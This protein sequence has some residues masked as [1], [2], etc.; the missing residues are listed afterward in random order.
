MLFEVGVAP[1]DEDA[2]EIDK[3]VLLLIASAPLLPSLVPGV[4]TL[5]FGPIIAS[6]AI[7]TFR[8]HCTT[9][10]PTRPATDLVQDGPFR[11]TRNPMY[12]ALGTCYAGLALMMDSTWSLLLLIPL[13]SVVNF[14]V[15]AR[16][17]HWI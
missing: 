15:T 8:R 12:L 9:T 2:V 1:L 14:F 7:R 11:C 10:L 5:L 16:V 6:S 17:R 13:V 3:D 4:F